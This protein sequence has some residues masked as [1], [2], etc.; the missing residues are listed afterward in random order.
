MS[1]DIEKMSR[2]N[3]A[4][5]LI[6][7]NDVKS[8]FELSSGKYFYYE[9]KGLKGVSEL[10]H[11]KIINNLIASKIIKQRVI[12]TYIYATFSKDFESIYIIRIGKHFFDY[13]RKARIELDR[14]SKNLKATKNTDLSLNFDTNKSVLS[15]GSYQVKISLKGDINNAHLVLEHIFTAEGG[16][17]HKYPYWEIAENTF[18]EEFYNWRRY[19]RACKDIQEKVRKK[20]GIED[21]LIFSCGESGSVYINEKYLE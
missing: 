10:R 1:Y 11:L 2:S 5:I 4:K 3:L 21:L 14:R 15:F 17:N 19:W 6:V 7:L 13:Y 12:L 9:V 16:L 8:E 20:T 18:K